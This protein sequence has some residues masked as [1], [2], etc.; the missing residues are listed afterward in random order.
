MKWAHPNQLLQLQMA[1]SA[2]EVVLE[3]STSL[4]KESH[5]KRCSSAL[6]VN[7]IERFPRQ[8]ETETP[9]SK[10]GFERETRL[11]SESDHNPSIVQHPKVLKHP[12]EQCLGQM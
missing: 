10:S 6:L 12:K 11:S 2:D 8:K 7:L 1:K 5:R 9:P 3:R 4:L